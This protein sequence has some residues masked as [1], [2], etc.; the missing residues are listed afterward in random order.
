MAASTAVVALSTGFTSPVQWTVS[1]LGTKL[2]WYTIPLAATTL[3]GVVVGNIRAGNA[4]SNNNG[5]TVQ[6]EVAVCNNDGTNVTI[7]GSACAN[8]ILPSAGIET[9]FTIPV[10]GPAITITAGQRIRFRVYIDDFEGAMASSLFDTTLYYNSATAN[11]SGDT[12]VVLPMDVVQYTSPTA[13]GSVLS[14]NS[15]TDTYTDETL[16]A[17]NE[18]TSDVL[19]PYHFTTGAG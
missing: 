1:R 8:T 19:G 5:A 16:D 7:F 4:T 13:F 15:K 9:T 14:Y 3:S 2:E 18:I 17:D 10:V 6:F 11:T 12:Y